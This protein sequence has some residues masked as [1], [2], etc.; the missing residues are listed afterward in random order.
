M[1]QLVGSGMMSYQ[2]PF[3]IC[4]HFHLLIGGGQDP[5]AA[6]WAEDLLLRLQ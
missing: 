6:E 5:E 3:L 1:G 2:V 4:E